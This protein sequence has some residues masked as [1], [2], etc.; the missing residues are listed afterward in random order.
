MMFVTANDSAW[1]ERK[2]SANGF[3]LNE[4]EEWPR[5]VVVVVVTLVKAREVEVD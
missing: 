5:E 3:E 2:R 1:V 4:A